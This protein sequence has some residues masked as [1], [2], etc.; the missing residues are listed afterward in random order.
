MK[1][2]CGCGATFRKRKGKIYA[3][4]ACGTR[5]RVRRHFEKH[6]R[7]TP[8][9]RQCACGC[10]D[11]QPLSPRHR[12]ATKACHAPGSVRSAPS[13]TQAHLVDGVTLKPCACGCGREFRIRPRAQQQMYATERCRERARRDARRESKAVRHPHA[14]LIWELRRDMDG[15][16]KKGY[17]LYCE[18]RLRPGR[19]LIC[20]LRDDLGREC[21]RMYHA[22][23]KRGR[24]QARKAAREAQK[25]EGHGP[26]VVHQTAPSYLSAAPP[27][28][29]TR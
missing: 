25:H 6:M 5:I 20:N 22:D 10:S 7:R 28:A 9:R 3:S 17:C 2:A 18:R 14:A 11:F 21:M 27:F 12:F 26:L 24:A 15:E 19:V 23:W 8:P 16:G 4:A 1:C 29:L 13:P